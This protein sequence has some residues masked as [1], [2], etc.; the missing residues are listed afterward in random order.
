MN[1]VGPL[2]KGDS[3]LPI[4]RDPE[5]PALRH[6][7]IPSS[8][9]RNI[10][11]AYLL[12]LLT[13]LTYFTYLLALLTYLTRPKRTIVIL[14]GPLEKGDSELSI[15]RNPEIPRFRYCC[16]WLLVCCSRSLDVQKRS[17]DNLHVDRWLGGYVC[18]CMYISGCDRW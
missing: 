5:I 2:E 18:M 7:E 3:E 11:Y 12:T 4:L 1:L 9:S 14:V 10:R 8:W 17:T 15:L 6:S 16:C 13:L